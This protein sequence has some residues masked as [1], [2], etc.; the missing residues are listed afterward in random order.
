MEWNEI[1]KPQWKPDK[2][3][4]V[5]SRKTRHSS[6]NRDSVNHVIYVMF[7]VY[8]TEDFKVLA[9]VHIHYLLVTST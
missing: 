7:H 8:C 6:L 5:A 1:I 4:N 3:S 2:M 9:I